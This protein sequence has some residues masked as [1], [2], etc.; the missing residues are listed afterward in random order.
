LIIICLFLLPEANTLSKEKNTAAAFDSIKNQVL[1]SIDS[2]IYTKDLSGKYTYANQAVLDLFDKKSD[3]VV[4]FDDSLFFDLA[5][6]KQLKKNDR[7]VM[8]QAIRIESEEQNDIKAKNEIRIFKSVKKPLFN[9]NG[10]V[11]GISTDITVEK[12]L[13][14]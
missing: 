8:D 9:S 12:K 3:E 2:F 1:D 5:L 14:E 7:Q 10:I 4:G 13:R 11:D 6:S